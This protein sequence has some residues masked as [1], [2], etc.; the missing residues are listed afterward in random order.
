MKNENKTYEYFDVTA[1]IGICAYGKTIEKSFQNAALATFE[2]ITDIKD[3]KPKLEKQ[4]KIQS[5]D[6]QALLYD[7]ITELIILLEA[8]QFISKEYIL[9]IT[10]VDKGYELE[11]TL[12]GELYDTMI[13]SYKTE[14]KAITY[15]KMEIKKD[16]CGYKLQFILDL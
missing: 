11:A 8:E 4:I 7:W 2:I 14:V 12:N 9:K 5:E 13:H 10:K 15:H 16:G 1:D 3:V 6:L